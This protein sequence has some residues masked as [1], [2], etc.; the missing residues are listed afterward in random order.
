MHRR[1]F[2]KSTVVGASAVGAGSCA[3]LGSTLTSA[4]A[5]VVAMV[6]ELRAKLDFIGTPAAMPELAGAP[7]GQAAEQ[8]HQL[9][10]ESVQTL[11]LA[12]SFHGMSEDVRAHP[13]VQKLMGEKLAMMNATALQMNQVAVN[14]T[15]DE[16]REL[17]RTLKEDPAVLGEA[18]QRLDQEAARLGLSGE[19]RLRLRAL[20]AQVG[21]RMK[22]SSSLAIEEYSHKVARIEARMA[23]PRA[24][25]R[26]YIARLGEQAFWDLQARQ[27]GYAAA[28]ADPVVIPAP[29]RPPPLPVESLDDGRGVTGGRM[30]RP[31]PK[32]IDPNAGSVAFPVGMSM[33]GLGVVGTFGGILLVSSLGIAGAFVITAGALL[34]IAG[35]IVAII[36]ANRQARAQRARS[37]P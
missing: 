35:L 8:H 1:S 9:F 6:D 11:V 5:D 20:F 23:E 4:G 13:A 28:W 29:V 30:K 33:L 17:T 27:E 37:S 15:A 25:E 32:P 2:L 22:Q 19:L 14:T 21:T 31:S 24:F 26:E 3:H 18:A 7:L 36:G 12:G 10:R 34:F 16:R